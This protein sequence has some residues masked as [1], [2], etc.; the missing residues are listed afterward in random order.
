MSL[1]GIEEQFQRDV[2]KLDS[3]D[4]SVRFLFPFGITEKS[5]WLQRVTKMKMCVRTGNLRLRKSFQHACG[6]REGVHARQFLEQLPRRRA[7]RAPTTYSCGK[8]PS[9]VT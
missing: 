7:S 8:I 3:I 2:S 1:S 6:W 5:Y 4:E 9:C